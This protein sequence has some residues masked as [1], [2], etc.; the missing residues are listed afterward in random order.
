MSGATAKAGAAATSAAAGL[1]FVTSSPV[2]SANA[3]SNPAGSPPGPAL[4][5]ADPDPPDNALPSTFTP[6]ITDLIVG[7]SN[8][9]EN[10]DPSSPIVSN[11]P[12]YSD[13]PRSSNPPPLDFDESFFASST[14]LVRR[15]LS[16]C[17][18]S[19]A[20]SRAFASRQ[21]ASSSSRFALSSEC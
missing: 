9:F 20:L 1:R 10:T 15:S 11:S 16:F 3:P 12:P 4:D 17:W 2:Y 6:A 19:V 8:G 13:F 21:F 14:P 18:T 7:H 5:V